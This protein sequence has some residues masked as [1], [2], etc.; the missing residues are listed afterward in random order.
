MKC[1]TMNMNYIPDDYFDE[2]TCQLLFNRMDDD[3]INH[4]NNSGE[5]SINFLAKRWRNIINSFPA[6]Y[7]EQYKAEN[8]K[9]GR[10]NWFKRYLEYPTKDIAQMPE[11]L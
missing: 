1:I 7:Y 10:N 2:D 3:Q 9:H 8:T 5:N 4:L 11:I 6:S